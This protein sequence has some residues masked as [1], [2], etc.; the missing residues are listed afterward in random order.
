VVKLWSESAGKLCSKST[1]KA[2]IFSD[3]CC[4]VDCPTD[5]CDDCSGVTAQITG[6]GSPCN[7]WTSTGPSAM[8]RTDCEWRETWYT[9]PP[10]SGDSLALTITCTGDEWEMELIATAVGVCENTW[11]ITQPNTSGCPPT[12]T[13]TLAL[14]GSPPQPGA[15]SSTLT[16]S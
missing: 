10:G 9:I 14:T 7:I 11:G 5:D 15:G 12:G 3:D 8:T 2:V 13:F 1:G 6:L 16:I 4:A